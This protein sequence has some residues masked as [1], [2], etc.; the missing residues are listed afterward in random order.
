MTMVSIGFSMICL[1]VPIMLMMIIFIAVMMKA[2]LIV[3]M[4]WIIVSINASSKS[5]C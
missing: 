4:V 2:G 3:V 5:E 1:I